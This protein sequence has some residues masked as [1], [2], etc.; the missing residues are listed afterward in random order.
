AELA[1]TAGRVSS[2]GRSGAGAP[3][4]S[5]IGCVGAFGTGRVSA[6]WIG[7]DSAVA[8]AGRVTPASDAALAGM[9]F[10]SVG[11]GASGCGWAGAA[12]AAAG[13]AGWAAAICE[14][15]TAFGS[16]AAAGSAV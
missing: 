6:A 10:D 3:S 14:A 8:V 15:I 9:D 11:A 13:G 2:R 1:S 16:V 5:S 4:A 7:A 12:T